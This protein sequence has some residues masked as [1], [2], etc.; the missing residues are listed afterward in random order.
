METLSAAANGAIGPATLQAPHA[1]QASSYL[2]GKR[3]H[4]LT[5][6]IATAARGI[7]IGCGP[8]HRVSALFLSPDRVAVP[9]TIWQGCRWDP[10]RRWMSPGKHANRSPRAI[11]DEGGGA[12]GHR[13]DRCACSESSAFRAVSSSSLKASRSTSRAA[14]RSMCGLA[15]DHSRPQKRHKTALSL[16]SSRQNGHSISG[17][18]VKAWQT[19]FLTEGF[20]KSHGGRQPSPAPAADF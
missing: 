14:A 18:R 19:V 8:I 15:S 2:R 1:V 9:L 10:A 20:Q 13:D 11:A 5:S 7:Q 17:H 16:I 4:G 12:P 6:G 3:S